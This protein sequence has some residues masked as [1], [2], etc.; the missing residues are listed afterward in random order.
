VRAGLLILS[1]LLSF[2][3]PGPEASHAPHIPAIVF[4]S[5][6]DDGDLVVMRRDG[7]H[8]RALTS[9]A[10]N[11]EAPSWSPSGRLVAFS[12]LEWPYST[13]Q[14]LDLSSGRTR[15]LGEGSNADWSPD[16]R[17]L[18]FVTRS[19]SFD[20]A[21]AD[22]DGSNRRVLGVTDLGVNAT[23][24]PA[25]SPQGDRLAFVGRQGLYVVG[26]N[27]SGARRIASVGRGGGASWSPS[28]E[29]IVFDCATETAAL[30]M[31]R[32]DGTG[33]REVTPRGHLP[34]W[35]P[36][37]GLIAAANY[38]HGTI[39]LFRLDGSVARELPARIDGAP[40]WSP[41]GSRIVVSHSAGAGN[42]LYATDP[43]GSRLARLT[44]SFIGDDLGAAWSPNR[45]WIVFHRQL[46]HRCSLELLDVRT[47]RLR[48]LLRTRTGQFCFERP[49][50][51]R[52]GRRILYTRKGD[53]WVISR[54]GGRP[55]RITHSRVIESSPR[56][57]PDGRSVAFVARGGI[58]LLRDGSRR[59]LVSRG[60]RFAW[61]H[62]GSMLAYEGYE[63]PTSPTS[64]YVRSGSGPAQLL[65]QYGSGPP[66]WS[67]N[68]QRIAFLLSDAELTGWS[69]AIGDLSGHAKEIVGDDPM[70]P[71]WRG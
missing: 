37:G 71:D 23:S 49:D 39:V 5:G 62:D 8:R 50:W 6:R 28:G 57:A 31:V 13:L 18:V 26:S 24:K 25:W 68:D 61:S 48:R 22:A 32:S 38:A 47:G 7:T 4:T 69:L 66:S 65:F 45:R 64:I 41:D 55:V 15:S 35:S 9:S 52:D 3:L 70:C 33:L 16:G 30:C 21:V 19:A 44:Q 67:P 27:G 12:V 51:S 46:V 53:L 34:S 29:R 40:D 63:T 42:R 10:R 1:A 2:A 59:L 60:G 36:R 20:L 58:W 43:D 56:W 14:V 17:R 54:G 11:D